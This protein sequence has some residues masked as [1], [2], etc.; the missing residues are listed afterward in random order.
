MNMT[1]HIGVLVRLPKTPFNLDLLL[2]AHVTI[3][4]GVGRI[5]PGL[6]LRIMVLHLLLLV[7]VASLLTHR[8]GYFTAPL[9]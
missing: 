9:V 1:A 3:V 2:N 4:V 8:I 6:V 7:E 5:T